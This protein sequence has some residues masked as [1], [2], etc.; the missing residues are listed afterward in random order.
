MLKMGG[1]GLDDLV[2]LAF[3]SVLEIYTSTELVDCARQ[4]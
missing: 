2:D 3:G 4:I 1:G